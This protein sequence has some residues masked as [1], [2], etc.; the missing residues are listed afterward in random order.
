MSTTSSKRIFVIDDESTHRILAKEYLEESGY[1][2]RL[3]ED[4][5]RALKMAKSVR[6]DLVLIDLMIPSMDGFELC[7]ALKNSD[8]MADVPVILVTASREQDVIVRGLQAGIDDFI[9]KPI[10]WAFLGDRV[11]HVL[12]LA[13]QKRRLTAEKQDLQE[14]L[15]VSRK[16]DLPNSTAV[17][18]PLVQ[19]GDADPAS[20]NAAETVEAALRAV[21]QSADAELQELESRYLT[22]LETQSKAAE[23]ESERHAQELAE[24]SARHEAALSEAKQ[25]ARDENE[26]ERAAL[27]ARIAEI[28]QEKEQAVQLALQQSAEDHERRVRELKDMLATVRLEKE[29][30]GD[31]YAKEIS[32]I[33]LVTEAR[34][35]REK[36]Q[37]SQQL[38]NMIACHAEQVSDLE[39]R[40]S[41]AMAE[42]RID[43]E[44]KHAFEDKLR[45]CWAITYSVT[46]SQHQALR[47]L[48]ERVRTVSNIKDDATGTEFPREAMLQVERALGNISSALGNL[49]ML[50]HMMSG[51]AMLDETDCNVSEAVLEVVQ[52]IKPFAAMNKVS[53]AYSLTDHPVRMRADRPRLIFS[54]INLM[55]NAIRHSPAG[56][57]VTISVRSGNDGDASIDVRDGGVGI[58]PIKLAALQACLDTPSGHLVDQKFGFGIPLAAAIARLHGGA[59]ELDSR[60]G[61]GTVAALHLPAN[62]NLDRSHSTETSSAA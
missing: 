45:S 24:C 40:L 53:V 2:V 36:E 11:A 6:P 8:G 38:E 46:S 4:G 30:A 43:A 35:S 19:T 54:L 12:D 26:G 58:A 57:E 52:K 25:S 47:Q 15:K 9:T 13:E 28:E 31:Q 55:M 33:R 51:N 34:L 3:A 42:P 44:T 50:A 23:A 14:Q 41:E 22:M 17:P 49:R 5:A 56:G 20:A 27:V 7:K 60:N 18:A 39:R 1:V 37:S 48:T 21:R 61:Q 32:D 16:R 62:R 59:L 29:R 10:D